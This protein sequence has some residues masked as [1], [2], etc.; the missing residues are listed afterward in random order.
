ML[1]A[2]PEKSPAETALRKAPPTSSSTAERTPCISSVPLNRGRTRRGVGWARMSDLTIWTFIREDPGV[3][4]ATLNQDTRYNGVWKPEGGK[5]AFLSLS[6]KGTG[7]YLVFPCLLRHFRFIFGFGFYS[8]S[9]IRSIGMTQL[10]QAPP[11]LFEKERRRGSSSL[12]SSA[13]PG[14][15]QALCLWLPTFELRLELVRA[16]ELD[17]TSVALLSPG[18]GV[19]RTLWR[20]SASAR[21]APGRRAAGGP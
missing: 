1:S 21:R 12:Y 9:W 20:W 14:S 11:L 4:A 18:E 13:F 17:A 16:P 8:V 3:W 15:R 5:R 10:H 2:F 19:R 7:L 6:G